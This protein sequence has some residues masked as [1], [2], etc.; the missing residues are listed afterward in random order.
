MS[1]AEFVERLNSRSKMYK[2]G[3]VLDTRHCI[4]LR[5]HPRHATRFET[6][7]SLIVA[8]NLL[9]RMTLN[10]VFDIPAAPIHEALPWQ[11]KSLAQLIQHEVCLNRPDQNYQFRPVQPEDYILNIGPEGGPVNIH[12]CGWFAFIGASCSSLP[13]QD[14]LN[15]IGAALASIIAITLLFDITPQPIRRD[16]IFD[17]FD[18]KSD[19][20]DFMKR[21][22][23]NFSSVGNLWFLG[24]GS[25]G[26]STLYFLS[27]ATQNFNP[28]LIDMDQVK[29]E[30]LDRSPIFRAEHVGLT[31]VRTAELFLNSIGVKTVR[32][33]SVPFSQ[34]QAR[35]NRQIGEPDV[36]ISAANEHDV[37]HTIELGMPPIQVYTTTGNEW[38]TTLLR[39]IP[40][41]DPCSCCIFPPEAHQ[42]ESVCGG[43]EIPIK[44]TGEKIDAAFPFLSFMAGL[45]TAAE[46]LKLTISGYPFN[47]HKITFWAS[48]KKKAPRFVS[49][50]RQKRLGC[51]CQTRHNDIHQKIISGSK[52]AHLSSPN[53][54]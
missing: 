3:R 34:S 13:Q 52:Y 29:I 14:G 12:S 50:K 20:K 40:F 26:S 18:W 17:S 31:K 5:V 8:A 42:S 48:H 24:L 54:D 53:P 30:N 45:M 10:I 44:E 51:V 7:V 36:F 37:R 23:N 6:Q 9:S 39:H 2:D 1:V 21:P 22:Y 32:T 46:I 49:Q 41:V 16:Y 11:N 47:H 28:T 38:Q 4:A 33:E 35:Q 27:L 43:G 19:C 25:V 15:P